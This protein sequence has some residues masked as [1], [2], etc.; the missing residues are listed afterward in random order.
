MT[1]E[2]EREAMSASSDPRVVAVRADAKV[3]EGTCAMVDECLSDEELVAWLDEVGAN[4]VKRAI[5][6]MRQYEA[7]YRG[8]EAEI[9]AEAGD[10]EGW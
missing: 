7:D 6:E 8:Y 2:R 9:M 5:R 4:T 10:P 1:D 3:G